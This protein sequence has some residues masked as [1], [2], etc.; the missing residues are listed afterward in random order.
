MIR[1]E[2]AAHTVLMTDGRVL[3]GL[4]VE[5]TP[6]AVT[7]V[8]EKN[9]RSVLPREK[10]EEMKVS[11]VSLMPEKLLDTLDDQQVRDLFSYVQSDGA[12]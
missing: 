7:L 1:P 12:K 10:I 9:E 11:P 4:I 2:F 8:N 5:S 3:T 6:G